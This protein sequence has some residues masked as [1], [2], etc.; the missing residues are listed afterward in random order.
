MS[1]TYASYGGVGRSQRAV[2]RRRQ[3]VVAGQQP[4]HAEMRTSRRE[5][6]QVLL[7]VGGVAVLPSTLFVQPAAADSLV[8]D[9]RPL[10]PHMG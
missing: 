3:R 2:Q 10:K 4:S 6:G 1:V 9:A 8:R 5:L 7:A